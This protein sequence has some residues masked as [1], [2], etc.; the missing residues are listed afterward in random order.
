[1]PSGDEYSLRRPGRP[2]RRRV[3]A[4]VTFW[5]ERSR[6][7]HATRG[8]GRSSAP[9]GG[10]PPQRTGICVWPLEETKIRRFGPKRGVR[11]VGE[12]TSRDNVVI[13]VLLR[14]RSGNPS[15]P[16]RDDYHDARP[17]PPLHFNDSRDSVPAVGK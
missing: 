8:C 14:P 7:G 13:D 12:P 1:M 3:N 10:P 2:I 9:G 4:G 5:G 6:T 16:G 17:T 15:A 11:T